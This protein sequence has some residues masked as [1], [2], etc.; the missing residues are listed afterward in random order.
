MSQSCS[1]VDVGSVVGRGVVGGRVAGPGGGVMSIDEGMVGGGTGSRTGSSGSG[2]RILVGP[3][4]GGRAAGGR[5]AGG[6]AFGVRVGGV[7]AGG[8][9]GGAAA[10]VGA[11]RVDLP[12]ELSQAQV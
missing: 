11:G 5:A 10:M 6:G 7:V 3:G 1:V 4:A 12:G 9:A 2:T 8:R